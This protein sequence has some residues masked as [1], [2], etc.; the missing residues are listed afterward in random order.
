[1]AKGFTKTARYNLV[2]PP[3]LAT[4]ADRTNLL[5]R[6]VVSYYLQVFQEHQ[7]LLKADNWLN[8][9]EYLTHETNQNPSPRYPF[10]TK[11]PNYPSGFRRSAI[12]EAYGLALAWRNSYRKWEEKKQKQAHKNLERQAN[13]KKPIKFD[14]RPSQYPSESDSWLVYYGT[15]HK[16]LDNHHVLLKLYTGQSYAYY[17]IPLMQPLYIPLGYKPGSPTLLKK[18]TGWELHVPMVQQT[19][20]MLKKIK[21]QVETANFRFCAVDLGM[22]R[23]A[24]LTIQDA[25]G[26]V[27]AVKFINSRKDNHLRKRYLEK[28]VALQKQTGVPAKGEKF[29]QHLWNKVSNLNEDIAH[30]VSKQIVDFA[31]H[32]S[33]KTIVFEHLGNLKPQKGTRSRW[34]NSKFNYWVKGR[35]FRYSQYKGLHS[36]IVTSR[37]SPKNTSK[38][39]PYCGQLTI[40]RYNP[41]K[42]KTGVDLAWCTSC[43][44]YGFNSDFVGSVGVGT[45][46]RRKHCA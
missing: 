36:G 6:Q 26:R 33:V 24:V 22:N 34:L 23:H 39:C 20:P 42:K 16:F 28:I 21:T 12:A 7:E 40:Q 1:M 31:L 38:R 11:F 35:I 9:A 30:R 44:T 43:D 17:K 27:L 5:Y 41:G 18:S 8:A 14:D 3:K 2:M 25:K 32:Y 4:L 13:G 45:T 46:F 10:D 29:A 15:A 19:R 37:V